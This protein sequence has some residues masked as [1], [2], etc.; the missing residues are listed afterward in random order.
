[1][2][3]FCIILLLGLLIT[4]SVFAQW[5]NNGYNQTAQT[6]QTITGTLQIIN[7]ILAIVNASNQVYYVPNLQPFYGTYGM[8]INTT[9]TVYGNVANNYI[10]LSR[11]MVC[12]IW[13]NL[14]V[15]NYY[16]VPPILPMYV[17][18]YVPPPS[19][20]YMGWFGSCW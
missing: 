1:M 2:K 3:K 19:R 11:F 10:D 13:Y 18:K 14:P 8:Y 7:G 5:G 17:P 15:Y 4:G 9:V 12:G 6:L 16:Y 20:T